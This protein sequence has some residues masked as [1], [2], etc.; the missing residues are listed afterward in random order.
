[1]ETIKKGGYLAPEAGVMTIM[2]DSSMLTV[3]G[4]NEGLLGSGFSYG[5][6]D[7]D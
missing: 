6:G 3:S 7:F 5:E 1:M 2:T 4:G